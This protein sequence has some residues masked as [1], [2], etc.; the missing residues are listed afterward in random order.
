MTY[1]EEC[2]F[3][4]EKNIYSVL[5]WWK[6][7]KLFFH[8]SWSTVLSKLLIFLYIFYMLFPYIIEW[9]CWSF[10]WIIYSFISAS[11]F[12][13]Y[14]VVG[15]WRHMSLLIIVPFWWINPFII[16]RLITLPQLT[17]YMYFVWYVFFVWYLYC[18]YI[19]LVIAL[20]MA[21]T[22]SRTQSGLPAT[23]LLC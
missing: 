20:C 17:F 3:A 4:L 7:L 6:V 19:S 18:Y 1:L 14:L 8:C 12:L 10:N 21:Y 5:V 9:V 23:V 16:I 2:F 13:I 15:Y 22:G 11:F